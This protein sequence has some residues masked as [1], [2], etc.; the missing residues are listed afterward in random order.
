MSESRSSATSYEI[1]IGGTTMSQ[2]ENEGVQT[3]IIEDHVDMV[4]MLTMKVGGAEGQPAWSFSIG[5]EVEAKVGEGNVLLF[6]G[7][8][9]ALEP[10]FQVDGISAITLRALDPLHIL[11]RG[12][13]TRFWEDVKDSAIVSEVGAECG[14]SVDADETDETMSYVLQRNESNIAFLKRLAA[15]NNCALRVDEGTLKF[16]K[17]QYDGEEVDI[18]LGENLRSLRISFNSLEQVSEVIVRGWDISAKEEV[19]GTASYADITAVGDGDIG[20]QVADAAFGESLAYITDVPVGSQTQADAIALAEMER[21]ARQFARGTGTI[22]GNDRVRAGAVVAFSGLNSPN[23][24]S[25]Y[26]LASRHIISNRTGYTTEFTFCS[27]TFG[28]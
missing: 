4:S 13:K 8:V 7:H 15:R 26:V 20:S 14:L 6:K 18:Q 28:S 22:Q 23:D 9:V 11:G 12:R 3:I 25:Y 27:N 1:T 10:S 19:V 5:D 17:N 21:L 24:G 2:P 16:L